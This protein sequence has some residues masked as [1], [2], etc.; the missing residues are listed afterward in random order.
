MRELVF[1][2]LANHLPR[3]RVSDKIRWLFYRWAGMHIE[4]RCSIYGPLTIRPGG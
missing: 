2:T 3:L 4:G 1:L